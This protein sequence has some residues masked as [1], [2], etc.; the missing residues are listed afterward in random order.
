MGKNMNKGVTLIA[1]IITI[2][3]LL[4]LAAVSIATLTGENGISNKTDKA[5]EE[6]NKQTAT[7]MMNLKIT[8][9]QIE[10]YAKTQQ[11]PTLQFLADNLCEDEEIEYVALTTQKIASLEESKLKSITVGQEKAIFTKLRDY[12]YEFEINTDL[13]LASINGVKV[14]EKEIEKIDE[15]EEEIKMLKELYQNLKSESTNPVGTL[16]SYMGNNVP[17]GYLPCNGQTYNIAEYSGLAEQIKREF[18]SYNYYGG[19]GTTTFAT[20]NVTGKFLKGSNQAG[21][22]EEA[23]LPNIT[24]HFL[25]YDWGKSDGVGAFRAE[26]DVKNQLASGSAS[27]YNHLR[28]KFDASRSSSI[29]GKSTTV[30]PENM[31]V[32]YCIKY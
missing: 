29:Y 10:S 2:I 3:V 31:S 27:E 32:L 13:K 19:D 8:N 26:I 9:A 12:P 24:G 22:R 15:L 28:F 25:A 4:I 16:I 1:L 7:E 17:N 18:G 21:I 11:M 20:P 14:A 23:G 6:T 5:S 30:T